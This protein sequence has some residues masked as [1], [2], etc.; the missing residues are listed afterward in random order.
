M[1]RSAFVIPALAAMLGFGSVGTALAASDEHENG[2]EIEA[3][4]GAKTTLGQAVTVA[5]QRTTGRALSANAEKEKSGYVYE[6][7]TLAKDKIAIVIVDPA[8]GTIVRSGKEGLIDRI[9]DQAEGREL[10]KFASSPIT[11]PEA[12]G[13]A[14]QQTGGKA[15]EA[16][17]ENEDGNPV[18]KVE[19]AKDSHVQKV[20]IDGTTG[21]AIEVSA[22]ENDEHDDD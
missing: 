21:K 12:I 20:K 18:L 6:V 19:V 5:E 8:T 15:I 14:E 2:K 4:L 3:V 7:K 11:L 17:Y 22:N 9:F 1:G 13:T 16:R 10:Q